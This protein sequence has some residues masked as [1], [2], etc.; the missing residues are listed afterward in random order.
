M[1]DKEKNENPEAGGPG[2]DSPSESGEFGLAAPTGK[3]GESNSSDRSGVGDPAANVSKTAAKTPGDFKQ[4]N[5]KGF[6]EEEEDPD[7]SVSFGDDSETKRDDLDMTPMVDVVFLLLIFFMVTASFTLQKSIE[8]PPSKIEDPSTNVIED[9][10]DED[11]Y[12]EVIIDQTNTYY[13]T[14]R[15]AEE[16]EAPSDR[17]MRDRMR[18]AKRTTGAPRLIINAHVESMHQKVV[19][20]WDAGN[21][22]GFDEIEMRTTDEDY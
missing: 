8:Q 4:M 5:W 15:D 18:D 10:E 21:A 19:T 1:T 16:V 7:P 3:F 6:E 9:P 17:E 2:D 20:V 13:V 11:D 22:A 14:S 12:V